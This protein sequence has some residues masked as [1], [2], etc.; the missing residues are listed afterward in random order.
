MALTVQVLSE[1][2]GMENADLII[3]KKVKEG[4]TQEMCLLS[5][6]AP[7]DVN[8]TITNGVNMFRQL[9]S[10]MSLFR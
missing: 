6:G 7:E 8:S 5:W 2:Y 9:G 10:I 1:R 3:N 4:M